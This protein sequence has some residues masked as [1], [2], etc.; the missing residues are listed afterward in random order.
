MMGLQV[1]VL[2]KRAELRCLPLP[3]LGDWDVLI[4]VRYSGLSMGSELAVA[5]GRDIAYGPPPFV[6]GYQA[7]G[8]V[9]AVGARVTTVRVGDWVAAF[10]PQSHSQYVRAVWTEVHRLPDGESSAMPAA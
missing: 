5:T 3:E 2:G 6:N 8:Q 7:T 1:T 4:R 9:A 10:C